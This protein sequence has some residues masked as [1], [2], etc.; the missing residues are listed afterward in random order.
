MNAVPLRVVEAPAPEIVFD[1][2]EGYPLIPD[3]TYTAICQSCE[4]KPTFKSLKTYFRFRVVDG[5]HAGKVL[6]RAYNV[7][8]KIIPGKGPGTG[9]RPKLARGLDLF[10]MLCRVLE[11]PANTKA[12]RV[13]SRELVGKLCTIKT[14]TVCHDHR[15]RPLADAS[16]YSVVDDI[17]SIE[18]GGLPVT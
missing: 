1:V 7:Q 9:P 8:G 15:Q 16:R 13:S 3:G 4:V 12:H 10:K 6:F 5:E 11:L 18:A 17:L 14:R 2:E